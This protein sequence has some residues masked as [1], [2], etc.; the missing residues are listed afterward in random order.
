VIDE[1]RLFP[2]TYQSPVAKQVRPLLTVLGLALL[3]LFGRAQLTLTSPLWIWV[4]S[5]VLLGLLI[6]GALNAGMCRVT[7]YV[8]RIEKRTWLGKQTWRREDVAR[9]WPR[10]TGGFWLEPP[11]DC[12]RPQLLR[13]WGY[14]H[15]EDDEQIFG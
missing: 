15:E 2:A 8:D 13:G 14:G 6:F 9:I 1:P 3:A 12:R 10:P 4:F 5:F 11:R 7:L